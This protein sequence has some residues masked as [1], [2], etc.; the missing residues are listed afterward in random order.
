MEVIKV[1][2]WFLLVIYY[3]VLNDQ[4]WVLRGVWNC[5]NFCQ[6]VITF[7]NSVNLI[8]DQQNV[9]SGPEVIKLFSC[10]TQLSVTS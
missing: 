1:V 3:V 10:S 9:S 5:F 7:A 4:G 2:Q 8:Q 6:Q